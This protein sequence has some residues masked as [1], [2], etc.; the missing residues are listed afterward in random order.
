MKYLNEE[1]FASIIAMLANDQNNT[2]ISYAA[3]CA[4]VQ[5]ESTNARILLDAYDGNRYLI[6][7]NE[8]NEQINVVV[9]FTLIASTVP[10]DEKGA[11]GILV[12]EN[13]DTYKDTLHEMGCIT[14]TDLGED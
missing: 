4:A 1:F 9:D 5:D 11:C 3:L 14:R 13:Y 8:G 10:V 12:F 6:V 7:R 2:E